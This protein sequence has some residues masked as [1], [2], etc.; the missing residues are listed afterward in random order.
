MEHA[1]KK[2][3]EVVVGNQEKLELKPI[4]KDGRGLYVS[5]EEGKLVIHGDFS[6]LDRIEG[7]GSV[8]ICIIGERRQSR[9][10]PVQAE[11][12]ETDNS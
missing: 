12:S 2:V 11:P 6:I 1:H 8:R 7:Y 9:R 3:R 10:P 4:E 5:T